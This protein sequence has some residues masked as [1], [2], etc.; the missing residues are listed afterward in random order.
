MEK[1]VR[2]ITMN[3]NLGIT[4]FLQVSWKEDLGNGFAITLSNGHSAWIGEVS[5]NDVSKEASDMEMDK[6]AYVDELKKAMILTATPS[7]KY[8]FDLIK[9]EES[10]EQYIFSYE[11]KLKEVSFKIGSLKVRNVNNPA[12]VIN[13]LIEH[14]LNCAT[15]LQ[16]NNE[17]LQKENERLRC[18]W[19]DMHEKLNKYV[20]GKEELEQELY[21]RFT[22]V[23]NKK[24]EKI[25]NLKEKLSESQQR[26]TQQ[27]IQ[28]KSQDS[29]PFD[30]VPISELKDEDYGGSTDEEVKSQKTTL[31]PDLILPLRRQL[32]KIPHLKERLCTNQKTLPILMTFSLTFN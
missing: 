12:E 31:Q 16:I 3:S 1:K 24:K 13:E 23:L 20:S 10:S 4:Y 15:E 25:R 26:E 17:H 27:K 22:C 9:D 8:T 28:Q 2:K 32:G 14:C 19:N 21:T 29:V 6:I 5:D 11:K 18:D 30:T 7:N